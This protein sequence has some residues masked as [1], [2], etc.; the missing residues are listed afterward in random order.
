MRDQ[1]LGLSWDVVVYEPAAASS[2]HMD[3]ERPFLGG[4]A[5]CVWVIPTLVSVGLSVPFC[6]LT[7]NWLQL[8][9][10]VAP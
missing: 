8:W 6:T 1:L 3:P 7:S 9:L 2:G 10:P 5:V 4:G